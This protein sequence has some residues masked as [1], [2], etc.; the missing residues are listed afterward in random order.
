M[1]IFNEL[2]LCIA[3]ILKKP[4]KITRKFNE[5]HS[6]NLTNWDPHPMILMDELSR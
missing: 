3:H 2:N 5:F 4:V 1:G 6:W